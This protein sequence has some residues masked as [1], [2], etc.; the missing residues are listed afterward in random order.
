MTQDERDPDDAPNRIELL[1][2]M[3]DD[4]SAPSTRRRFV[5]GVAGI[6]ASLGFAGT[7]SAIDPTG[8]YA[9]HERKRAY[10]TQSAVRAAFEDHAEDLFDRLAEEDL[11]DASPAELV[12][13]E[14]AD[15]SAFM[16]G[17]EPSAHL[18]VETQTDEGRLTINVE[19]EAGRRYA[20]LRDGDGSATVFDPEQ[21]AETSGCYM[22]AGCIG[23][24]CVCTDYE[25]CCDTTT[26]TCYTDGSIGTCSGCDYCVNNDCEDVCGFY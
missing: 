19:P 15:V 16:V 24:G 8:K 5:T 3:G 14:G 26:N 12:A 23:D 10:Q 9:L 22:V 1:S 20:L 2:S 11:L 13:E 17:G 25:V 21:D 18:H 7:A 4:E 6:A